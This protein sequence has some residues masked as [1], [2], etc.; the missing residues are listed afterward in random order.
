[1][2]LVD[3]NKILFNYDCRVV[4]YT[5]KSMIPTFIIIVEFNKSPLYWGQFAGT[6]QVTE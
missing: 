4:K 3:K 6:Y 2:Y 5:Y 1:M